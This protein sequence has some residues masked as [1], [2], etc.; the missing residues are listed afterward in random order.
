MPDAVTD[1]VGGAVVFVIMASKK[2]N[3]TVSAPIEV[4]NV[5][6][7]IEVR[8]G[9]AKMGDLTVSHSGVDWRASGKRSATSVTWDQLAELLA[10]KGA[11]S[12]SRPPKAAAQPKSSRPGR[13]PKAAGQTAP[14]K[15]SR[16]AARA[17]GQTAPKKTSRTA[18]TTKPRKTAERALPTAKEIRAWA[19]ESGIA[20]NPRGNVS[21]AVMDRYRAAHQ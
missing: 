14:E 5:D 8:S 10:A 11:A 19:K 6:V 20:V 15:T 9:N 3:L 13:A 18:A 12:A 1:M 16:A 17:A 21:T 7:K 4:G 2:I